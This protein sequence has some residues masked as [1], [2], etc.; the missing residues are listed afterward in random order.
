MDMRDDD[1]K[2][3]LE[4]IANCICE[5]IRQDQMLIHGGLYEGGFGVLLFLCYY[6]RYS[7]RKDIICLTE[8]YMNVLIDQL[9]INTVSH[10]YCSGLSGILYL[11]EFLRENDFFDVSIDDEEEVLDQ[12]LIK[13]IKENMQQGYFDFLHGVVGV[14]FYFI[15]RGK[16]EVLINDIINYLYDIAEKDD[17]NNVFKWKSI[18]NMK[19]DI[20][21]SIALSHGMSSIALFLI[22]TIK[23]GYQNDKINVMLEGI[24]NYILLQEMDGIQEGSYFPSYSLESDGGIPYRSRLGWCYGDLGVAFTLWEAGKILKKEWIVNKGFKVLLDSTKRTSMVEK[25]V[26]DSGICHG[27]IGLVMIYRRMYIETNNSAFLVAMEDWL[28]VAL[29]FNMQGGVA[30][31]K[32]YAGT[33]WLND[34][35]LLMGVS[36]IGLVFLSYITGGKQSWD[37]LFLLSL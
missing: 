18:L 24:V 20:G 10:T 16:H 22:R 35:S 31:Y 6:S 7:N 32:S 12:Y 34:Y 1:V 9:D 25:S 4:Q 3:R 36:G 19:K 27:S 11:F 37:E 26:V 14:G 33:E 23:N 17:V 30:G 8:K 28:K 21:Y 2:N 29:Q 13:G 15:K 5:K